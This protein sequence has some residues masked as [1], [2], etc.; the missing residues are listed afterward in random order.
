MA[1]CMHDV[2]TRY[3]PC[4]WND[5]SMQFQ[6]MAPH[7]LQSHRSLNCDITE[8]AKYPPKR[9]TSSHW[10]MEKH[11][12]WIYIVLHSVAIKWISVF[13]PSYFGWSHIASYIQLNYGKFKKVCNHIT[14][15]SLSI[16]TNACHAG[17]N[18]TCMETDICT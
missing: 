4:P 11:C 5:G 3:L 6:I 13:L 2:A 14:C 10:P 1:T 7:E 18:A 8:S 16:A 17:C 12:V 9:Q 15:S